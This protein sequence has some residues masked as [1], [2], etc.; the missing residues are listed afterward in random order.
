MSQEDSEICRYCFEDLDCELGNIFEPC[1]CN[2]KVHKECFIHWLNVR[3]YD[4][5][6]NE[7]QLNRCEIC[8]SKYKTRYMGYVR[9][10]YQQRNLLGNI[11]TIRNNNRQ[12]RQ[13]RNDSEQ[14]N[15]CLWIGGFC[16]LF[17]IASSQTN[18]DNT[19]YQDNYY[20]QTNH[21][22]NHNLTY[23]NVTIDSYY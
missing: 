18:Y 5:L 16:L 19:E 13:R 17:L 22:N 7:I 8:N 11:T 9:T 20:N 4:P 1:S 12:R 6:S 14:H 15:V 10:A 21:D 3:P 23:T 2:S